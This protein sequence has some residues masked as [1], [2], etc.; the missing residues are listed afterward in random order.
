M[1]AIDGMNANMRQN[2]PWRR[3]VKIAGLALGIA[4]FGGTGLS[5][6]L[7]Q[8]DDAV[9]ISG[10]SSV[11]DDDFINS[12]LA[13][14]FANV[15]G[16]GISDDGDDDSGAGDINVGGNTGGSVTMGGSSGSGIAVGG[17][18]GSAGGITVGSM[19]SD[20]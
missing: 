16:G 2:D 10:G 8:Q 14:V 3:R 1:A 17:S 13:E 15:F 4:A 6:T 20:G 7:A 12:I 19:D 9:S 11:V 5:G 18:G